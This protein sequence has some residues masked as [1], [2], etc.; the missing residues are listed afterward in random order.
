[1]SR[2]ETTLNLE[3]PAKDAAEIWAL[4]ESRFIKSKL[5]HPPM[6][7]VDLEDVA[8]WRAIRS[9]FLDSWTAACKA[10]GK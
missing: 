5:A 6:L 3:I 4:V 10:Y 2:E 9:N 7:K 1:M 8:K